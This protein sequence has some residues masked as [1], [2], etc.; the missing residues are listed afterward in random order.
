MEFGELLKQFLI[1]LQS[2]FRYHT[3]NLH[4]TLPQI[5][6]ISSISPDGIDM[7]SLAHQIGVD[8]STL[9]RLIDVLIE[10]GVVIKKKNPSD[11]RSVIVYLTKKGEK[12]RSQIESE[13]DKFGLDLFRKVPIEDQEELKEILSN[14]HWIVSKYRLNV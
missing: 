6:L 14:F 8:N 4:I 12:M 3:K 11:G 13:I 7:T 10:K 1:D 2:L 9:T 5:V